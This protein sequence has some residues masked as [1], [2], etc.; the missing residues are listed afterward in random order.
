M[1][2]NG[3]RLLLHP[4]VVERYRVALREARDDLDEMHCRHLNEL[5]DLRREVAELRSIFQDVVATLRQQAEQDVHALRAKLEAA[6]ARLE[7]R[8][9][10]Q[11]LH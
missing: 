4:S 1:Q 3:R 8:D 9:P 7:R 6:L 5:E 2:N 10:T 11:P